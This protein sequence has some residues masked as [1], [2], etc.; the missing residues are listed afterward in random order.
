M[1]KLLSFGIKNNYRMYSRGRKATENKS[2]L[3]LV[4]LQVENIALFNHK[5]GNLDQLSLI[6][7]SDRNFKFIFVNNLQ[8]INPFQNLFIDIE[9]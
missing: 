9:S 8:N 2:A 7:A 4:P 6:F 1:V 3:K 5:L